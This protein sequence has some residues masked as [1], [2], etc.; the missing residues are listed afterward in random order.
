[1]DPQHRLILELACESFTMWQGCVSAAKAT[2]TSGLSDQLPWPIYVGIQFMEYANLPGSR[3]QGNN[4]FAATSK[5]FSVAAGRVAFAFGLSGPA[6]AI[7]TACSSALVAIH[8]AQHYLIT[9][10]S[11]AD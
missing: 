4:P 1:M 3:A 2:P 11:N 5:N 9:P 8:L 6:V 7:D 10:G